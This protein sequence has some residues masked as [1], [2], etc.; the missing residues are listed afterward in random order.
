MEET[1]RWAPARLQ[2]PVPAN[3]DAGPMDSIKL[4]S[5][6]S[7][8][9]ARSSS[10]LAPPD[11]RP[12]ALPCAPSALCIRQ[13]SYRAGATTILDRVDLVVPAGELVAVAG[14]SGAGKTTLVEVV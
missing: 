2:A 10:A 5:S 1:S 13:L 7:S 9:P 6:P 3:A 12:A 8:A 14:G 4:P 11:A